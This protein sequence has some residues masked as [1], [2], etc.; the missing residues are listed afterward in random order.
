MAAEIRL[1]RIET[2]REL[3]GALRRF[4]GRTS[5][6]V[7]SLEIEL[8]RTLDSVSGNVLTLQRRIEH[9]EREADAAREALSL[10][11]SREEEDGPPDC[12][13]EECELTR[14]LQALDKARR[15]YQRG[16]IL[17]THVGNAISEFQPLLQ[18]LRELCT[19]GGNESVAFI[20]NRINT[21]EQYLA[22]SEPVADPLLASSENAPSA[23]D[24]GSGKDALVAVDRESAGA[25]GK[26][27]SRRVEDFDLA[28]LPMPEDI[29]GRRDFVKV[30][31]KEMQE[32]LMKLEEIRL[33]LKTGN[34]MNSDHW[35]GVD[36]EKGFEYA[37]GYQ[38]VYDA[39]YGI[40]P[41]RIERTGNTYTLINGRHRVWAA[42]QMG[43]KTLPVVLIEPGENQLA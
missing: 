6:A 26:W 31:L 9:A 22:V 36:K 41:I 3:V 16:K 43:I 2:L 7:N 18:R 10:C 27:V 30:T 5:S 25:S 17:E 21:V 35:A 11:E 28:S 13:A 1:L 14:A 39:F 42:K 12:S 34:G 8:K 4:S 32:G 40:E 24:Y 37:N 38:R 20:E 33:V 15:V 23:Q 29:V 19:S